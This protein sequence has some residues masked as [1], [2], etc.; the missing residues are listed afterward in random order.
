M[1]PYIAEIRFR[2]GGT[3]FMGMKRSMITEFRLLL[4]SYYSI[5]SEAFA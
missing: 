1:I 3:K 2:T 4:G 5:L